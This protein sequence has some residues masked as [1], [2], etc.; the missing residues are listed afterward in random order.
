MPGWS[1]TAA[2]F[3]E[4]F[5]IILPALTAWRE[6]QLPSQNEKVLTLNPA[7]GIS[8]CHHKLLHF[9][10]VFLIS[11]EPKASFEGGGVTFE[12]WE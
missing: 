2:R 10:R 6:A 9:L 7:D 5:K 11:P 3:T 8:L 12:T 4:S 1:E